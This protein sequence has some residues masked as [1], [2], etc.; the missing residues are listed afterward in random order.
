MTMPL[1]PFRL[2]LVWRSWIPPQSPDWY[3]VEA[4]RID[5]NSVQL[6][7]FHYSFQG[8]QTCPFTWKQ[9]LVSHVR[10]V[11]SWEES[12]SLSRR[13]EV[14]GIDE[15]LIKKWEGMAKHWIREVK[16]STNIHKSAHVTP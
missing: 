5:D 1:Y 8:F 16:G 9:E 3:F 15:F 7:L 13:A 12:F 2:D 14:I 11:K 4:H 6:H 10:Y